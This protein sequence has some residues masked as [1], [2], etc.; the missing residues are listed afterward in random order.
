MLRLSAF[1]CQRYL[2]A[3]RSFTLSPVSPKL[4]AYVEVQNV[5][6]LSYTV[7]TLYSFERN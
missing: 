4:Q 6:R 7:D 5:A 2:L 1:H 3:S